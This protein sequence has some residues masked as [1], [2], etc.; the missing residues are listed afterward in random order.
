[1]SLGEMLVVVCVVCGGVLSE[2]QWG[3]ISMHDSPYPD[4]SDCTWKIEVRP[5]RTVRLTFEMLGIDGQ[6][7]QCRGDYVEVPNNQITILNT[8]HLHTAI[9]N[10]NLIIHQKDSF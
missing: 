10:H 3:S 2:R 5:G 9:V 4:N 1:M 6:P 8:L 7:G